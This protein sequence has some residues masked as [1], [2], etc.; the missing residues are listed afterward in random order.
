MKTLL[1]ISLLFLS[2]DILFARI[3]PQANFQVTEK[4]FSV[5][6]TQIVNL[7]AAKRNFRPKLGLRRA[8]KLAESYIEKE[9]IDVSSFYL[10]QARFIMYGSKDKQQPAWHLWWV[11]ENGA[12]GNYIEILVMANTGSVSRLPSM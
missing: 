1:A 3:N 9:K 8:L 12:A 7:P 11:N 6:Q 2:N 5:R 10:Y 4:E